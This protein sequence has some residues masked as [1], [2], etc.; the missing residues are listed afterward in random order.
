MYDIFFSF[1]KAF[2]VTEDV[3]NFYN[4]CLKFYFSKSNKKAMGNSDFNASSIE[5]INSYNE[6]V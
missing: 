3:C 1:K 6:I 5:W 2:Y 4:T